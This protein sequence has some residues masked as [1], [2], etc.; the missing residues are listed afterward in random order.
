MMTITRYKYVVAS[1][2]LQYVP[3]AWAEMVALKVIDNLTIPINEHQS[4][5]VATIDSEIAGFLTYTRYP[6]Q[7][8]TWIN[9]SYTR[10]QFRRRGVHTSLFNELVRQERGEDGIKQI[11]GGVST[12]NHQ[13]QGAALASG[14]KPSHTL[15][16]FD[17]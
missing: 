16:T 3:M 13:M 2:I 12:A 7:G 5:F 11:V 10:Q 9:L 6:P 17:L 8:Y 1:G 4:A 15:L 14:R